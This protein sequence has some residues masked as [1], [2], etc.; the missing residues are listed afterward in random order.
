MVLPFVV[1]VECDREC[2]CGVYA[3]TK[4][5]KADACRKISEFFKQQQTNRIPSPSPSPRA[6]PV[7]ERERER[8]VGVERCVRSLETQTTMTG[9]DL[10]NLIEKAS[11]SDLSA[12]L[13]LVYC[14]WCIYIL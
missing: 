11:K 2:G 5:P 10:I 7:V 4:L 1:C 13:K 8:G 14:L 3:G 12:S 6:L 9:P